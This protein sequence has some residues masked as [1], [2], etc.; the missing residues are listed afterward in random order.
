[1]P[2]LQN[3]HINL[4]HVNIRTARPGDTLQLS[5]NVPSSR[6]EIC[7]WDLPTCELKTFSLSGVALGD[8]QLNYQ[9]KT[10]VRRS[11]LQHHH[12]M[13]VAALLSICLARSEAICITFDFQDF[14][15]GL[16]QLRIGHTAVSD[17]LQA[18]ALKL[19]VYLAKHVKVLDVASLEELLSKLASNPMSPVCTQSTS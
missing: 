13:H 2:C 5:D 6:D 4:Q 7:A 9:Q 10:K 3:L 11:A 14:W 1:M 8:R 17:D 15:G 12:I 18:T 19:L 16:E